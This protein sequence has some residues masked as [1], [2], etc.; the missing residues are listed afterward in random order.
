MKHRKALHDIEDTIEMI[1]LIILIVALF[2]G[3]CITYFNK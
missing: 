3:L 2:I 1:P